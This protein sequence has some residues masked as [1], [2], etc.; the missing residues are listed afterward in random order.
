MNPKMKHTPFT[1][2]TLKFLAHAIENQSD[3]DYNDVRELLEDYNVDN[4]GDLEPHQMQE[5]GE[6]LL[7]ML[8]GGKPDE[9]DFKGVP[10]DIRSGLT[11]GE[12]SRIISEMGLSPDEEE[13]V[14]KVCKCGLPDNDDYEDRGEPD[15]DDGEDDDNYPETREE[16]LDYAKYIVIKSL[17]HISKALTR[18]DRVVNLSK[19][20]CPDIIMNN[21]CRMVLQSLYPAWADLSEAR[22][23][24]KEIFDATVTKKSGGRK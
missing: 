13:A 10:K 5:V 7:Q 14:R 20:D 3:A 22:G 24:I 21:E 19:L 12:M 1:A 16:K 11:A 15:Y 2:N 17:E 23:Y 18:F 4:T 8:V 9:N 6:I